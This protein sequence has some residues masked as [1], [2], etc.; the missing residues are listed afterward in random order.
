MWRPCQVNSC[1]SAYF[2]RKA[3]KF[4]GLVSQSPRRI[5]TTAFKACSLLLQLWHAYYI[6]PEA[7]LI[8]ML[9]NVMLTFGSLSCSLAQNNFHWIFAYFQKKK[10]KKKAGRSS[11]VEGLCQFSFKNQF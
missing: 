5:K 10:K 11:Y 8:R 9:M 7:T 3:C 4:F 1:S 6:F 2:Y